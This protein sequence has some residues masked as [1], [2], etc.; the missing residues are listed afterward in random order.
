[1][2][3][4]LARIFGAIIGQKLFMSGIFMTVG[5]IILYN[6]IVEVVDELMTFSLAQISGA[7]PGVGSV[8]S[9]TITGFAGWWIAELKVP[10]AFA[11]IVSFVSVKFMLRKIPFL[12]W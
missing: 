6:L 11:V 10:E 8:I 2:F 1:M 4:W 7:G 5:A 9:P 3:A 12:R